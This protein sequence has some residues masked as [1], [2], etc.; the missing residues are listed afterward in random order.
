MKTSII[1]LALLLLVILVGCVDNTSAIKHCNSLGL[2][3]TGKFMGSD[4]ECIN[5]TSQ[6]LFVYAADF[7]FK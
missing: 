7:K 3:W 1:I 2:D 5:V 6:Q 4:I